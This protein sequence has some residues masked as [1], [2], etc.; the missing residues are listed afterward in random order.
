MTI[1]PVALSHR[2]PILTDNRK[3][4]PMDELEILPCHLPGRTWTYRFSCTTFPS[5]I[6]VTGS[7]AL[8]SSSG[9]VR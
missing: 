2:L 6:T 1:A 9:Q 4:F 5:R 8:I 7:I 3:H